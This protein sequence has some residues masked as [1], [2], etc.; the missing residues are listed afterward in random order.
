MA[1]DIVLEAEIDSGF[2]FLPVLKV[3]DFIRTE[4]ILLFRGI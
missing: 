4:C 3:G 1:Q 2:H